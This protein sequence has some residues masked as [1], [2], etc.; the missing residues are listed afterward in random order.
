MSTA[1]E[2]LNDNDRDYLKA[3][4]EFFARMT[5]VFDVVLRLFSRRVL[6]EQEKE[7]LIRLVA[8]NDKRKTAA[9]KINFKCTSKKKKLII[10]IV[11]NSNCVFQM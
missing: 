10:V 6:S 1:D 2:K 4:H 11:C 9:S 3:N 7:H 8:D 5:S